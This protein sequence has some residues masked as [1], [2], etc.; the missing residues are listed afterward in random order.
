MA[1]AYVALEPA[2]AE[3]LRLALLEP[4]DAGT[5]LS[6]CCDLADPERLRGAHV[7]VLRRGQTVGAE[8]NLSGDEERRVQQRF[9]NHNERRFTFESRRVGPT[10]TSPPDSLTPHIFVAF[11]QTERT[12]ADAGAALQKIQPLANRRRLVYR[13]GTHSLDLEP[14]L[15]GIL[16]EYSSLAGLAIGKKIVSYQTMHQTTALETQFTEA[17]KL[18]PWYVVAD[19]HVDRDLDVGALRVLE[20]TPIV[21]P[22]AMRVGV[23]VGGAR[24]RRTRPG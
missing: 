19:G 12:S 16:A 14:A 23:R 21:G 7:T 5:Y 2:A 10:P 1:E 3:G 17:A 4:P 22:P 6:M 13:I 24:P 9:G 8:L 18:V 20:G 11:D 15:G